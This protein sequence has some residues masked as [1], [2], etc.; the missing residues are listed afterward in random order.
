MKK[1]HQTQ[2][3]NT[4]SVVQDLLWKLVHQLNHVY[5]GSNKSGHQQ[6]QLKHVHCKCLVGLNMDQEENINEKSVTTIIRFQSKLHL[7]CF[8]LQNN[9]TEI[10][11]SMSHP[12][13]LVW[14]KITWRCHIS[15]A[16]ASDSHKRQPRICLS[17]PLIIASAISSTDYL[18]IVNLS[19]ERWFVISWIISSCMDTCYVKA[20]FLALHYISECC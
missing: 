12:H 7:L 2:K 11:I 18:S 14:N 9:H 3:D 8:S 16:Y 5:R 15:L 10:G 20:W 1:A 13:P 4:I 17:F 19:I 6:D